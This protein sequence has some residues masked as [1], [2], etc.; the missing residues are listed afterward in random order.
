M[1]S[2]INA[3]PS[4][5][6]VGS[7]VR[8]SRRPRHRM[9]QHHS[10]PPHARLVWDFYSYPTQYLD[11]GCLC[12]PL[13]QLGAGMEAKMSKNV[14]GLFDKTVQIKGTKKFEKICYRP[15][16]LALDYTEGCH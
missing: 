16:Y 9:V 1:S 8:I 3:S 7:T 13:T 10:T 4:L 6:A 12:K 15:I 11:L 5:H 14:S 2:L